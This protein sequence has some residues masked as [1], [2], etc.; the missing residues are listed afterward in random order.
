MKKGL[1]L[2]LS[3]NYCLYKIVGRYGTNLVLLP[4]DEEKDQVLILEPDMLKE[5]IEN[6]E[7]IVYEKLVQRLIE[8]DFKEFGNG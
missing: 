8:D 4:L 1:I 7:F 6:G 3:G 5:F 2:M